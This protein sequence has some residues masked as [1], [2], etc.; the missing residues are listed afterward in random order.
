M[1]IK[2]P[3]CVRFRSCRILMA[4]PSRLCCQRQRKPERC[5]TARVVSGPDAAAVRIN[6]RAANGQSQ[7]GATLYCFIG[8]LGLLKGGEDLFFGAGRYAS[9]LIANLDGYRF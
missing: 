7:P 1:A 3:F 2:I 6:N 4:L 5:S 9:A 8:K